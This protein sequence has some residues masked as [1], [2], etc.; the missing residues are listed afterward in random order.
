MFMVIHDTCPSLIITK[1]CPTVQ[2]ETSTFY[3]PH[4]MAPGRHIQQPDLHLGRS[5]LV[6]Q[7]SP[8]CLQPKCGHF[9]AFAKTFLFAQYWSFY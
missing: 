5:V 9:R 3:S 2:P 8:S 7:P 1:Y 4:T 6:E